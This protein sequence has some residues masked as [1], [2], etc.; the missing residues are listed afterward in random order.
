MQPDGSF[1]VKMGSP[2]LTFL[3]NRMRVFVRPRVPLMHVEIIQSVGWPEQMDPSLRTGG[4]WSE[5]L[6]DE[7]FEGLNEKV[8]HYGD[9]AATK[10][11]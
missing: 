4:E 6:K 11:K 10:K 2:C 8:R 7:L 5:L 1:L 3:N 9:E